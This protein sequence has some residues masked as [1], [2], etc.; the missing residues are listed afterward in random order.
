MD[1]EETNQII[2]KSQLVI[3]KQ[4]AVVLLQGLLLPTS[5]SHSVWEIFKCHLCAK[6]SITDCMAPGEE[7]NDC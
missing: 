4:I 5:D 6:S 3:K 1:L 2:W 7:C